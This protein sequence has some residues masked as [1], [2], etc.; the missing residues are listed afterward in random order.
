LF[1]RGLKT[2]L[3]TNIAQ[4]MVF[5]VFWKAIEGKLNAAAEAK[6]AAAATAAKTPV[7][8]GKNVKKGG[9]TGSISLAALPAF[10]EPITVA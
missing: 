9:K 2:R 10:N 7:K 8:G 3:I 4:S 1:G 6:A 5:S